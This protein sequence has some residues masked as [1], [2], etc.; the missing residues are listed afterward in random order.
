MADKK[1]PN[2]VTGFAYAILFAQEQAKNP[3]L[4]PDQF[5]DWLRKTV[6]DGAAEAKK[7]EAAGKKEAKS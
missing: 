4:T 7:A 6:N 5:K 3:D 2:D 1:L